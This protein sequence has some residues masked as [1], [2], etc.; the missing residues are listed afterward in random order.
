MPTSRCI[1]EGAFQPAAWLSS[2]F[3][4][5]LETYGQ[6]VFAGIADEND[7]LKS[8]PHLGEN[9]NRSFH[10]LEQLKDMSQECAPL[11]M[12]LDGDWPARTPA[13][14]APRAFRFSCEAVFI[15]PA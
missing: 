14:Q 8:S 2:G 15:P 7:A 5:D 12:V 10:S 6:R 11:Q 4:A 3:W 13:E 9:G 1:A